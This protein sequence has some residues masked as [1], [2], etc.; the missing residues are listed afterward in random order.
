MS[1]LPKKCSSVLDFQMVNV[2]DFVV[3]S[4]NLTPGYKS[5]GGQ[6]WVVGVKQ[7][8]LHS[9]FN[10]EYIESE[11]QKFERNVPITRLTVSTP[12]QQSAQLANNKK[13]HSKD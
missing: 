8:H 3:V 7:E 1:P 2:G 5:F 9:Y 6:G 11:T 4:P 10:V 12:P 13:Q